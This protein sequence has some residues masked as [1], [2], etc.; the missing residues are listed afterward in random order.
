MK[1]IAL[2]VLLGL[3]ALSSMISLS[4]PVSFAQEEP[5]PEPKPEKPGE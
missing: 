4:A 1:K 2:A 3:T 5:A